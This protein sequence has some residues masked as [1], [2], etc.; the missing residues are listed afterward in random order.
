MDTTT[1]FTWFNKGNAF[2]NI[3][4]G[5]S[6]AQVT[7]QKKLLPV[8]AACVRKTPDRNANAMKKVHNFPQRPKVSALKNGFSAQV[9]STTPCVTVPACAGKKLTQ[10]HHKSFTKYK[11]NVESLTL[12][13][14]FQALPVEEPNLEHSNVHTLDIKSPQNYPKATQL[15]QWN[16]I[17]LDKAISHK[18]VL[19]A[20]PSMVISKPATPDIAQIKVTKGDLTLGMTN[21]ADDIYADNMLH[22]QFDS[23]MASG[24]TKNVPE[25]VWQNRLYSKDYKACVYQNGDNFGYI[26]LNDLHVYKG[27]EIQWKSLPD[28]WQANKLIRETKVPNFLNCRIPVKTQLNPDKWRSYLTH[29]WDQQLPDLIQYGF[30]LDFNRDSNLVSTHVNHTS[31]IEHE[32]HIDQYIA[33][34]LKYGA[35]YG[36]FEDT[37]I[38]VH[39]SPLMTRAKQN[40]DK[41][42]TIVDLSW[43]KNASVNAA[44][45]KNVYLGSHFVLKYPSLDDITTELRKLG[46]GALIYKVNISRAFRHIRIDPGDI[47]LLGIRH[48]SLFLDGSLPFGFRLGSGIFE[49][50]SDAIRYIM[51]NFGHNALMNYIDD[52][53]YIGLPSKIYNSY[54]QLLSLLEELGLEI[55]QSKLVPPSTSV[56]CLGI[57]VNTVARTLS[58]PDEKLAEIRQLCEQWVH[59]KNCT[60]N[61]LQ[62]LLGSLLYITR[63]VRPA[64]NFLNRMLQILRDNVHTNFIT[65]SHHFFQDL[66]WFRVFLHHF[67][68]VTFYDNKLIHHEVNLDA[69]LNGLGACFGNEVYALPL[70]VNFMNLHITQL[71]MLNVVVALKVWANIWANKRIKISCDNLAVV[72]ILKSGKTRDPFLATCA[73]N[74]WLITAMF[75]I[76]IILIHVPGVNNQVADLLSRWTITSNPQSKLMQILPQFQWIDTHIDLTKL[77]YF[78]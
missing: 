24:Q 28:I 56:V 7:A 4:N 40:S 70:P 44:V 47:D 11:P 54:S 69:S 78:I 76:D 72:E 5:R 74:I 13:N 77:N 43:P 53:I 8:P 55:S 26:P 20:P 64:R 9:R 68:G 31:A 32:K 37:P 33:E 21:A 58:I 25:D 14:R 67:N 52:L 17:S 36:P 50:Y 57:Q 45:Q 35:L 65:L 51:K 12:T 23:H 30:P 3:R 29:Y 42:R 22:G 6:Y 1:L 2:A 39:V 48:K 18:N 59:K 62:S 66:E 38:P 16:N 19:P 27:P 10:A 63:C 73:R 49:R 41:R 75:N 71:E 15:P 61:Q 60:K 46:P 34:E